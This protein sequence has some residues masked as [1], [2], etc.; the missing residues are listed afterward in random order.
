MKITS[1]EGIPVRL[2]RPRE[3]ALGTAGSPTALEGSDSS[4]RWSPAVQAL[5]SIHFETAL[6]KVTI[7][8]GR[9][10]WGEA[11]APLAPQVACEIVRLLLA[12][13]LTGV[14]FDGSTHTIRCLW[15]RM[16][17]TMRVRGQTGGFMLDAISGVDIALWDLAGKVQGRPVSGL[18]AEESADCV[19]AYYSGVPGG[20]AA[21][22][23]GHASAAAGQGFRVFKL[24]YD[25]EAENLLQRMDAI[26]AAVPESRMA[27]DALWRLTPESGASFGAELD[28]RNALWLEAPL[29]PEDAGAHRELARNIRTPLAV[30]ESYRTVFEL[31]PFLRDGVAGFVQPDL[32]RCGLT[33]FLRIAR[34][35]RAAGA[36]VVPHVS[37]ALGP[38]IAAAIHAAAA[39]GCR[40]LEYN[41]NVFSVANKY[42]RT[43]L[44]IENASYA[45]P[46]GPGL[47]IAVEEEKLRAAI[48][49]D[50]I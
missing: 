12:P 38:Q 33:E 5:Y 27:V 11:Q 15:D 8:D 23:A 22:A 3:Q 2:A 34:E 42:L 29:P 48:L 16:Y 19:P 17:Q 37:I 39:A 46:A 49:P 31:Q 4:Y 41:P 45:V 13:V 50:R 1:I 6:V 10:G 36:E 44:C 32:G 14:E 28:R 30:G 18:I 20:T 40:W 21:Q 26:A 47:G 24:F 25:G 43:P 35:A 7:D 9:T